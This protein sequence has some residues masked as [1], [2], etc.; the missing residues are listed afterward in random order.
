M[1]T[2]ESKSRS[3]VVNVSGTV[4]S[5]DASGRATITGSGVDGGAG[6]D[7]IENRSLI[8]LAGTSIARGSGVSVG[9]GG[10]SNATAV[11]ASDATIS[12][13]QRPEPNCWEPPS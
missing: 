12:W 7:T 3:I 2:A 6:D 8:N 13:P 9:G 11:T 5:A 10:T 4:S 1:L